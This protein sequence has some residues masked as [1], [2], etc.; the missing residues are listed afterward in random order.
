MDMRVA[1]GLDV[2]EGAKIDCCGQGFEFYRGG[3][4]PV[5]FGDVLLFFGEGVRVGG[6]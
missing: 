2:R 6:G 5:C 4:R 1:V 3:G